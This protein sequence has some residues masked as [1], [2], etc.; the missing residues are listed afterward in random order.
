LRCA[1]RHGQSFLLGLGIRSGVT[2]V[3]P[4][5]GIY[6]GDMLHEAGHLAVTTL[7][8]RATKILTPTPTDEMAAIAWSYTAAINIGLATTNLFHDAYRRARKSL[9]ENFSHDHCFGTI[10]AFYGMTIEPRCASFEGPPPYPHML[11]WQ[12]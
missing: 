1:R 3:I 2:A 11:R 8:E 6:P 9:A 12:R 4:A 5:R 10:P 7:E